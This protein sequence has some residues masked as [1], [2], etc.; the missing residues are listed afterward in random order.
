MRAPLDAGRF[1]QEERKTTMI[2]NIKFVLAAAA[3]SSALTLSPIGAAAMPLA[4]KDVVAQTSDSAGIEQ[5]HAV[6]VCRHGRCWW[7]HGGHHH[8]G[9]WGWGGG[10]HWGG[11]HGGWGWG[12]H[13]GGHWG[14]HHGGHWGGHHG[15][16]HW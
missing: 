7:S 12:G 1:D 15:G 4:S 10:G 5:T 16:H 9:G 14:G 11:H 8:G 3:A 6:W 13:H 2:K